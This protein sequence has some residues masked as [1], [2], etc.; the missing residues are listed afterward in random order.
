V[1]DQTFTSSVSYIKDAKGN[2]VGHIG[3]V[4]NITAESQRKEYMEKEINK[5]SK[6][7]KKMAAGDFGF[8][9]DF[10]IEPPNKYTETEYQLFTI[11]SDN[12]QNVFDAIKELTLDINKAIGYVTEGELTYRTDTE[13][14]YGEYKK[15]TE[16]INNLVEMF[17]KPLLFAMEFIHDI[18]T[19]NKGI[20][21]MDEMYKGDFNE[22]K[23]SINNT[24]DAL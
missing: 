12:L 6:N 1:G 8:D 4:D 3:M 15:I 24:F 23:N 21:R 10:S 20:K 9:I 2:N 22:L 7:I 13:G 14:H 16:G 11:I 17:A 18:A 5:L 19:G